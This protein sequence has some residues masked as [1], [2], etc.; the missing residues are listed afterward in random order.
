M[1]LELPRNLERVMSST[2]RIENLL[3]SVRDTTPGVKRWP[4]GTIV[5]RWTAAGVIEAE[6]HLRKIVGYPRTA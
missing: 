3:G 4:G 5:L 6:R 2:N 1:R